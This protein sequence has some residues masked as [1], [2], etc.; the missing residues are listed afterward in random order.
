MK[1][2]RV[3]AP[4]GPE[5]LRWEDVP[6]P[7]PAAGEVTLEVKAASVNHLDVWIRKGLPGV[8]YPRILGCDAAGVVR[9]TGQR[10]LLNPATSCGV[11]EFCADGQKPLCRQYS[12]WGEHRDGT[13]AQ[14]LC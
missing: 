14:I 7:V 8:T 3:H 5:V 1:A 2:I 9:E 11:C 13:Y 6:D 12:I 10:V 4:G